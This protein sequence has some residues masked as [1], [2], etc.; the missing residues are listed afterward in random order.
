VGHTKISNSEEMNE[1]I[2]MNSN[3][4]IRKSSCAQKTEIRRIMV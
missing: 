4:V 1:K 2:G 3:S